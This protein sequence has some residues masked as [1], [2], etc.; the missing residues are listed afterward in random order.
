MVEVEEI[1]DGCERKD[2]RMRVWH[3]LKQEKKTCGCDTAQ[4][5][6]LSE[7]TQCAPRLVI[8]QR[9]NSGSFKQRHTTKKYTVPGLLDCTKD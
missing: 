4:P 1:G 5:L 7:L 9:S 8:A 2:A 3:Y 6:G